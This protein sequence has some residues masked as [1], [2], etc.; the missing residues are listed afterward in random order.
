MDL[1]GET[2]TATVP[3]YILKLTLIPTVKCGSYLTLKK[4][5]LVAN[6]DDYTKPQ[7]IVGSPASQSR[8]I[9]NTTSVPKVQGISWARRLERLESLL[10]EC[11]SQE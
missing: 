9:Y 10:R 7:P 8:Y 3:N 1:R 5:L 6:R 11:V 4:L 2:T